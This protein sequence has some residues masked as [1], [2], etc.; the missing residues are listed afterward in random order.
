MKRKRIVK[1]AVICA[2]IALA[3]AIG[4]LAA[5]GD[6]SKIPKLYFEGDISDMESKSD[7][8]DISFAYVDGDSR[9]EGFAS[10]KVQGTSSLYYEKKNYTIKLYSDAEHNEKY[11]INVGWGEHNT[12]CLKANW[13]DRTHARNI[14]TARLA[15]QVQQKYDV[16]TQAPRNGLIDGF[17]IEIYCNGDFLGL[18]TLNIPKSD[19]QF[20]MD[21]DNPNHI[22]LCGEEWEPAALFFEQPNF[23]SW[24]VEVGEENDDTLEKT[25]ALFEFIIN[26]TDDEFRKHFEEHLDLDAALN[27]YVLT[28]FAYMEDNLGK[29]MLLVTYDGVKWYLSLYDL[30]TTWGTKYNGY[31]E[32][33]YD[34]HLLDLSK[35]NL[36]KRM[37]TCF[38]QELAERYFELRE[39]ILNKEHIMAEF[40][41]FRDQIPVT[42]FWKEAWKWGS[43]AIRRT[44]DLPGYDYSQI[45]RYL[46]TVVDN[47]DAKYTD[48][49]AE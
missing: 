27:Y 33:E 20:A 21:S 3:V 13:I 40:E 41:T 2:L 10:L 26:G 7:I 35:N 9:I 37:E 38:S 39:D 22:V 14:V 42:S 29:N 23:S 30:D 12:Y 15:T 45:E 44:E 36:F 34:D 5:W 28:D 17:P 46:D 8:R 24:S 1:I 6:N 47:L 4:V 48:M 16:L 25:K 19:W 49:L 31:G 32:Y 18:Y 11:G 43:G